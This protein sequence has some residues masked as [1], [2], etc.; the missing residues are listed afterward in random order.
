MSVSARVYCNCFE[1]GIIQSPPYPEFLYVDEGGAI[2]WRN[3]E[4]SLLVELD[5]WRRNACEHERGIY[6][7]RDIGNIALVA[8]LRAELSRERKSFPVLLEK[9]LYNGMHA[10]DCLS[11]QDLSRLKHELEIV[12]EF[13]PVDSEMIQYLRSFANTMG[14]LVESAQLLKKPIEF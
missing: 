9:V 11:P 10:G 14:E 4:P 13:Q 1:R 12:E 3:L 7:S 2:A 8:D 5:E 6:I